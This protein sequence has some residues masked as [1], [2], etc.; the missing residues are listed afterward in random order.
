MPVLMVY[1]VGYFSWPHSLFAKL[2][3]C[4][5]VFQAIV[6]KK[7]LTSARTYLIFS[8]NDISKSIFFFIKAKNVAEDENSTPP[9][10]TP[11]KRI[12]FYG[13]FSLSN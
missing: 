12:K 3:T 10:T 1:V 2:V 4:I 6:K 13:R 5:I 7:K 11:Y 9:E 8:V